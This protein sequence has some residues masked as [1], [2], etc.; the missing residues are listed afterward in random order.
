MTPLDTV[1]KILDLARW[2]PS[3]DNTQVWEFEILAADHVAVHCHDTRDHCVYDLHG[4]PSQISYGALL[5][6]LSIAA[7]GFGL[8]A[9]VS[10][11]G[12]E[13]APVFQVRL[14]ADPLVQASALIPSIKRRTVQRRPLERRPLSAEQ[15]RQLEAAVGEGYTIQ[16]IE[17]AQRRR[18]AMLMYRNARLRLTMP[19]AFEV[20]RSIIEWDARHSLDKVPDQALGV[21]AMTT[22]LMR[23]AMHSWPRMKTVNTLMGTWAPRL[24]MDL[25]PGLACAAHYVIK[26]RQA[27]QGIDDYVAAGRAVQRFW[28]TLT[29]LGLLMQPEMTPLIFTSYLRQGIR[30]SVLPQMERAARRLE[31]QMASLIETDAAAPV[32]M[33]RLGYGPQPRARS[34]RK[35]L[36]ELLR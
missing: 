25:I 3:G 12:S 28:L 6:T 23:W 21:D 31:G 35:S 7:S 24:Q 8:R 22:K 19:E 30:F 2:A 1:V 10:R 32:Y 36:G 20:H 17:G 18:A 33:G 9:D 5:E 27:P 13:L 29:A 16:W 14:R 4:H 26:A 11:E 15:K 34:L